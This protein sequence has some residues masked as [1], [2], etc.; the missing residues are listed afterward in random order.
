M[1]K[2]KRYV[3][4]QVRSRGGEAPFGRDFLAELREAKESAELGYVCGSE[5]TAIG[6]QLVIT[7]TCGTVL[8]DDA[9]RAMDNIASR[10]PGCR[11]VTRHKDRHTGQVRRTQVDLIID[12]SV[13]R[14][15]R[16]SLGLRFR[17]EV[18]TYVQRQSELARRREEEAAKK[19]EEE[20]N[21]VPPVPFMS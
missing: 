3:N 19:A 2:G 8:T 20:S 6:G 15:T 13:P 11:S 1:V 9:V 18:I 7:F 17:D 5:P 14:N 10:V 4:R 12:S 21:P 16:T